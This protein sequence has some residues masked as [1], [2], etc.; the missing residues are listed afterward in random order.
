LLDESA[1]CNTRHLHL[2][3]VDT[4]IESEERAKAAAWGGMPVVIVNPSFLVGP[5][6]DAHVP[7]AIARV[8][9]RGLRWV[10]QGGV[11]V[12]DVE[13]VARGTIAALERGRPGER[14][15][16]AGHN[17]SWN[18]FY[19]QLAREVGASPSFLVMPSIAA[20]SLAR[21][22]RLL[23]LVGLA[24]PP[25]TPEVF[26]TAGWFV[27]ADSSKAQRELGYSIRPLEATLKR[28][29]EASARRTADSS[30]RTAS[31]R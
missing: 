16:L 26:R 21:G 3:Y 12:A 4:K 24:R 23:D 10:P 29:A 7:S 27:Y 20:W 25:W 8:R 11:S 18:E 30:P 9:R 31:A 17:L 15:I 13:D 22:T 1:V 19:A 6:H 14:Y 5:R 28:L 2:N